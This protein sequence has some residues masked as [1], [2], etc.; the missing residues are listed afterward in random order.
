MEFLLML[1]Q[2]NYNKLSRGWRKQA[3][4][5]TFYFLISHF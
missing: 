2:S 3:L 4:A 5:S 1:V